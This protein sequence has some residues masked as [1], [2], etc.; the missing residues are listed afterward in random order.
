MALQVVLL[1]TQ[2]INMRFNVKL[3]KSNLIGLAKRLFGITGGFCWLP[4]VAGV[5][6]WCL[7][8]YNREG[9]PAFGQKLC[10]VG[11]GVVSIYLRVMHYYRAAALWTGSSISE[12]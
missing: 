12:K 9:Q 8:G 1:E 3:G 11:V 10:R 2:H 4:V 6:E 7:S 5:H